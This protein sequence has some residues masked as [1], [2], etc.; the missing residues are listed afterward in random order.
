VAR[1]NRAKE[2]VGVEGSPPS[3]EIDRATLLRCRTQD[4]IAFQAFVARYERLVFAV[5]SQLLGHGP[6]VEDLAQES[7]LRAYVAF[8]RFDLDRAK[9]SRWLLT[10]AVRLALN[11]RTKVS[12]RAQAD[13]RALQPTASTTPESELGRNEL[14]SIIE[15]AIAQLPPGQRE[16]FV[17][18]ELHDMTLAEIAAALRIPE[19]TVKTRLFR[20]REH[21]RTRLAR[22]RKGEHG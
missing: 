20:A 13:L 11:E 5:L 10:I 22:S 14:G 16:V 7:F 15:R 12:G 9:P 19:N 21:L 18:A 1:P 2:A 17:L 4:H 6:H 3:P 8:P